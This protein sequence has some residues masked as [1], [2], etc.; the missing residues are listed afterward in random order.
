MKNR[1]MG[2]APLALFV[3]I[4]T[5]CSSS[6]D[7]DPV[8]VPVELTEASLALDWGVTREQELAC[9]GSEVGGGAVSGTGVFTDIGQLSIELSSVWD[10]GNLLDP[11]EVSFEPQG[12][13][14]GPVAP[15]FG[16]GEYPYDFQF[17]PL[18]G[19]CG[20]GVS[21]TGELLLT[22]QNGDR[23]FGLI[24]G[25]E[26]HRLDFVLE[27]DGIETF[28]TVEL[29]GGTGRFDKATGSF[30]VHTITRFD[31]VAGVFVID[32]AEVLPGGTIAF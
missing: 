13:A 12:P 8:T 29:D 27:G 21:A 20:A 10:I 3:V 9:G 14:G 24:T 23:M 18:A 16:L 31:L 26:T 2:L 17:N 19:Q 28:A 6:T 25:G 32:L 15:V 7:R 11:A 22:A 5:G 30:V 1:L 4:V